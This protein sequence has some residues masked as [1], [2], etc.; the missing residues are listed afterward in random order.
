MSITVNSQKIN[1][2]EILDKS[3]RKLI[4][5]G[6]GS[7]D[8]KAREILLPRGKEEA[9]AFYGNSELYKAYCLLFDMNVVNIYTCNCYSESDYLRAT[10]KI[11]HYDF[12]FFIPIGIFFSDKFYNPLTDSNEYYAEFFVKQLAEV[13]NLT[14]VLMTDRHASLYEDF[15]SFIFTMNKIEQDFTSD[16]NIRDKSLLAN[17]GNNLN[18]IYNNIEDVPYSNVLLGALYCTRDYANYFPD[19]K[20]KNVVFNINNIDVQGLRGMYFKYNYYT[21]TITVENPFNFKVELDIYANA[22]IDDIIKM[23]IRAIDL[24]KYKGM[25]YTPYVCMQIKDDITRTLSQL[26]GK[27]IKSY[28]INDVSFRKTGPTSGYIV[29]D[30]SITPYGTLENINVVMGAI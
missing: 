23:A 13:N 20:E 27:I 29:A 18:F 25:L 19:V 6:S 11:I 22:L 7:S 2:N 28:K 1:R 26:S 30:Y 8:L 16:L 12:D 3:K 9:L 21:N 24:S 14:T 17:F 10:D 5:L 15:D 4:L